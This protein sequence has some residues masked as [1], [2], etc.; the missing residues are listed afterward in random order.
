M[1]S[2]ASNPASVDPGALGSTGAGSLDSTQSAPAVVP[3]V[4]HSGPTTADLSSNSFVNAAMKHP[5]H[6]G[7]I[8]SA[9][10]LTA[11][12]SASIPSPP[13]VTNL[14]VGAALTVAFAVFAVLGVFVY[15]RRMRKQSDAL[16]FLEVGEK[17]IPVSR[18]AAAAFPASVKAKKIGEPMLINTTVS[19]AMRGPGVIAA[20]S[21]R[22]V[23]PTGKKPKPKLSI[24][25]YRQSNASTCSGPLHSPS[26]SP[27]YRTAPDMFGDDHLGI[28]TPTYAPSPRRQ[29]S[30]DCAPS[31]M[32]T[33][34]RQRYGRYEYGDAMVNHS[35]PRVV[36]HRRSVSNQR[37]ALVAK[38]ARMAFYGQ[39]GLNR[40]STASSQGGDSL[41]S[42]PITARYSV[43]TEIHGMI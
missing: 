24:A 5:T 6:A 4:S 22:A 43:E 14:V 38:N 29:S 27:R 2:S 10:S 34:S 32:P 26:P 42:I 11:G 3:S 15:R 40:I 16:M 28:G 18:P 41:L 12:S 35:T 8:A 13:N 21:V 17:D 23:S 39:Q 9:Q 30:F 20:G 36:G 1:S 37:N 19:E 25:M 31:P 33:D 7:D